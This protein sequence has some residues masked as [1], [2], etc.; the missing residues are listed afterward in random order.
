VS[1]VLIHTAELVVVELVFTAQPTPTSG[2]LSHTSALASLLKDKAVK[3]TTALMALSAKPFQ[4]HA[5]PPSQSVKVVN[6]LP[7]GV[8]L[9]PTIFALTDLYAQMQSAPLLCR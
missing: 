4:I 3:S 9:V 2:R 1:H 6:V 7:N 8:V 5:A